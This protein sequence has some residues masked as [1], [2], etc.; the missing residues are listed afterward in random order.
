MDKR[1]QQH[2]WTRIIKISATLIVG[3]LVALPL[4][5]IIH[6]ARG[7][8]L[9]LIISSGLASRLWFTFWQS[10]LTVMVSL[11]IGGGIALAEHT[12]ALQP[13]RWFIA[14][15]TLPVF[16]PSVVVALGFVAVWGN[17]GYINDALVWLGIHRIQFLY[18][19]IAVVASHAFYNIPL[20]YIAIRLRLLT[21]ENHLENS[22]QL[23]GASL[24]K[25]LLSITLPRL[26]ST[27]IGISLVVFLYSFMSFA[28][29]LILGGIHYQTIEV[30]IYSLI[31]Q[32]Y[33][34]AAAATIALFQFGILIVVVLC[35]SRWI[36]EVPE[37][38]IT[39]P[40]STS[41]LHNRS[42]RVVKTLQYILALYIILPILAVSI[43]GLTAEGWSLLYHSNFLEAWLRTVGLAI[44]TAIITIGISIGIIV[45]ESRWQKGVLYILAISPVT[46]GFAWRLLFGQIFWLLPI[47]YGTLLLPL[48]MYSLR[49]IWASRPADFMGTIAV[50]GGNQFHQLIASIRWLLPACVQVVAL[51]MTFVFGDIAV[52]SILAPSD[53][54]TAMLV[55]YD[56]VGSYRFSTAAAGMTAVILSIA[57]CLSSIYLLPY[58]YGSRR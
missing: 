22:A 35:G 21:A 7:S 19:G 6:I 53:Q 31:T 29:P 49:T 34:F 27:I 1:V 37:T 54:P 45:S 26:Q 46:L 33:D 14:V 10:I 39:L 30:Y 57:I 13:R 47:A 48:A 28:L 11:L 8:D 56:L 40:R 5:Y 20:V 24:R 25:R 44:V 36:R 16:L 18:S 15:M 41:V 43:R 58:M 51:V 32:Q 9:S 17:A 52:A 38:R 50:L 23:L 2:V 12:V 3:I 4:S 42:H 55:A